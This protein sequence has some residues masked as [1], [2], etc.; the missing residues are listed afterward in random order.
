MIK[1]RKFKREDIFYILELAHLNAKDTVI[2][3]YR[4]DDMEWGANVMSWAFGSEKD[5]VFFYV[6]IKKDKLVG[7]FIGLP[8][9]WHYSEDKYLEFKELIVDESLSQT[10]KARIVIEFEAIAEEE[11]RDTGLKGLSAF[12]IRN[13]SQSY[14]NF[15]TKR[16]GWTPCSGAKKIF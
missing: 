11:A 9:T 1:Y 2:E 8:S 4:Y 12:S 16:L 7:F 5:E 13:D 3:G 15:Y 14:A 6:A 10:D